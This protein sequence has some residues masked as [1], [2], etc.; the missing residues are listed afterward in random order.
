M[1]DNLKDFI[2]SIGR[3][4]FL[5]FR[6]L[7]ILFAKLAFKPFSEYSLVLIISNMLIFKREFR[8]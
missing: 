7:N 3:L 1:Q 6:M 8:K 5:C 4:S 2:I